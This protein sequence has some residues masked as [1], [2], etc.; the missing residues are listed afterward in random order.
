MTNPYGLFLYSDGGPNHRLTYVSVQLSLIALFLNFDLD[1]LI[2]CRTAPSHCWANP[3]ERIM[4]II[5]L[6]LQCIGIMRTRM[7]E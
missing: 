4:S 1:I 5:N 3:V 6:G 2:A 7:G